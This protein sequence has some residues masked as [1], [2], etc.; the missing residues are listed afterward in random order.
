MYA[1]KTSYTITVYNKPR[2]TITSADFT[3]DDDDFAPYE[4]IIT[5]N[6]HN[7]KEL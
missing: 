6:W 2:L 7:I 1:Y 4:D 5:M 3:I